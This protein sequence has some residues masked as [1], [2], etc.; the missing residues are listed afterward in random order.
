[1]A[2]RRKI[3]NPRP[4]RDRRVRQCERFARLIR[5]T[6]LLLGHGRWTPDGLARELGCSIR[7][8][9]RDISTLSM[10]GIPIHFDKERECYRVPD[11]FRFPG[12]DPPSIGSASPQVLA[13]IDQC[14]RLLDD[15]RSHLRDT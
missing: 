4:D 5:L 10:A 7:T 2:S 8:V 12:V 15:L 14:Q 1:M 3:P 13:V 9:F 11:G 6:Q